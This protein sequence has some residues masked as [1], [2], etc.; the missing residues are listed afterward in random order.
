[1]CVSERARE[2]VSKIDRRGGIKR[3][4]KSNEGEKTRDLMVFILYFQQ[5]THARPAS[6]IVFDTLFIYIYIHGIVEKNSIRVIYRLAFPSSF[7]LVPSA[8][9]PTH[10]IIRFDV[11]VIVRAVL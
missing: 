6:L 5:A 11:V 1:M 7:L 3:R 2:R 4:E 10:T 9:H 8:L